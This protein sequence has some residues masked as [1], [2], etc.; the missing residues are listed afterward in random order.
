MVNNDEYRQVVDR[1]A[2][3]E[4]EVAVLRR[5]KATWDAFTE[6]ISAL[7]P[8]AGKPQ[9]VTEALLDKVVETTAL[10]ARL[11]DVEGGAELNR[12]LHQHT[13][14]LLDRLLAAAAPVAAC[15]WAYM[16]C[17]AGLTWAAWEKLRTTVQE[18]KK[19]WPTDS[20]PPPSPPAG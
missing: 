6:S 3:L 11:K 10:K 8:H 13:R 2:A 18:V 20:P 14:E 15:P 16:F 4:A 1:V 9:M 19:T 5:L 12:L 17:P 7:E